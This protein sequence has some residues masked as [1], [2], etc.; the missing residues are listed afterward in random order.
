MWTQEEIDSLMHVVEN[1]KENGMINW[2]I[3]ITH[4]PQNTKTQLKSYFQK[5]MRTEL[6]YFRWTEA[7]E[8]KLIQA[9]SDL[10]RKWDKIQKLFPSFTKNQLTSK[11]NNIKKRQ[12]HNPHPKPK[13]ATID[14]TKTDT[15]LTNENADQLLDELMKLMSLNGM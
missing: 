3:V 8:Q 14:T 1:S 10:N 11:Y 2:D 13:K 5:H 12:L 7:D 6:V 9:A 15:L 4:F